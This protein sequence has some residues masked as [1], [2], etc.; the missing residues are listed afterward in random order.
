MPEI[1]IPYRHIMTLNC[2]LYRISWGA[3]FATGSDVL[4]AATV[5]EDMQKLSLKLLTR[6]WTCVECGSMLYE[7]KCILITVLPVVGDPSIVAGV[8]RGAVAAA[9]AEIH[10]SHERNLQWHKEEPG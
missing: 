5:R 8:R 1:P 2:T 4:G 3:L 6:E 7:N 10:R 9:A